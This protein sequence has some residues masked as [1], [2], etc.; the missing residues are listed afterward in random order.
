MTLLDLLAAVAFILLLVGAVIAA[1]TVLEAAL[2]ELRFRLSRRP[3]GERVEH[4]EP[5]TL[6]LSD[7][8][9]RARLRAWRERERLA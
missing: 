9:V 8:G 1:T 6:A 3:R 4:D 7:G 2:L 5:P